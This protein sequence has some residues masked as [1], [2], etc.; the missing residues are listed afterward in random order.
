MRLTDLPIGEH[1]PERVHAVIEIPKASKNKFE[2]IPEWNA[3]YLDRILSTP[4]RFPTAYGFIPQTAG[5]DG[6]TIDIL[7]IQDEPAVTGCVVEARPLGLLRMTRPNAEPVDEKV[8]AVSACDPMY[9]DFLTLRDLPRYLLREIDYF[10]RSYRDLEGKEYATEWGGE[11]EVYETIRRGHDA[12]L[13][14]RAAGRPDLPAADSVEHSTR[15]SR[16]HTEVPDE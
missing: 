12:Y 9:R 11:T 8:I 6:D 4:L 1:A 10:F 5:M 15:S 14:K 16:R 7:V 2:Y 3:F 13:E